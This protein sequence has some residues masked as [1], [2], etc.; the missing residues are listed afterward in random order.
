VVWDGMTGDGVAARPG[1]YV[2]QLEAD[3]RRAGLRIPFLR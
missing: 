3:G 1:V 2:A